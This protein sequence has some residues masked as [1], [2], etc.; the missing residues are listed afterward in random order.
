VLVSAEIALALALSAGAAVMIR[1]GAHAGDAHIG[2]DPHPLVGGSVVVSAERGTVSREAT[3]LADL[4]E[5][6]RRMPGVTEAA[7]RTGRSIRTNLLTYTDETGAREF[8]APGYYYSI[9]SPGY[10]RTMR[11]PIMRGSDFPEGQQD[12]PMVIVDAHTARLLWPLSNPIGKRIKL[13]QRDTKLPYARV[14]GVV[15][16]QPG[17][18]VEMPPG[19]P[20]LN[21]LGRIYYL[22]GPADSV[23]SDGSFS[24]SF[25]TRA[26]GNPTA[27]VLRIHNEVFQWPETIVV[28]VRSLED[29]LLDRRRNAQF[30]AAI[31]TL[32][33]VAGVGLAAFGV[34]GVVAYS[35]AERRREIGVRVALGASARDIL[36]VVLHESFVVALAGIAVGLLF[37]KY[38][39]MLFRDKAW[40]DDL[41][42]A[43]LF[44]AIAL[45]LLATS[46]LTAYFPARRAAR[47]EATESLR[48]E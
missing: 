30:I 10:F 8:P 31:F 44:A 39:V 11:L 47:T 38:G 37:T 18:E 35:V 33:S 21:H 41:Y 15:G 23:V 27:E 36:K 7:A 45:L 20:V 17:Y 29:D 25:V 28:R 46:M 4:V 40:G 1:A 43:P 14:V 26:A 42:N 6:L 3:Q 24:F 22:P 34:Y 32:F 2:Y 12:E 19:T 9:V 48:N 5:R 16:E 13:G